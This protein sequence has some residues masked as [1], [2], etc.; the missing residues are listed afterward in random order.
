VHGVSA[1]V[2]GGVSGLPGHGPSGSAAYKGNAY[3]LGPRVRQEP[4]AAQDLPTP[5]GEGDAGISGTVYDVSG[6]RV[7]GAVVALSSLNAKVKKTAATDEEGSFRFEGLPEG[8]YQVEVSKPGF[9]LYQQRGVALDASKPALELSVVLAP[10]AVVQEVD[11]TAKGPAGAVPKPN[12]GSGQIWVDEQVEAEK[13]I[14]SAPP[15]Y[16][17]LAKMARIQ[18]TVRLAATISKDGTIQNLKV[19]AGHPLLVKAALESVQRW[20]YE[21]TLLNGQPVEVVTTIAVPFDQSVDVAAKGPSGAAWKPDLSP[22]RIRV[23]GLIEA[24]KLVSSAP[25]EYPQSARERG[26]QGV[27]VLEGVISMQGEPLSLKVLNSPDPDLA[28]AAL[29]AVKQWRYEPTLLNG[30]PIEVVSTIAVRF[31]LEP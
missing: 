26:I 9:A 10:G 2:L 27:V 14:S 6:A 5:D 30:E 31:H 20:R 21:P 7:P 28:K 3:A 24:T 1:G 17:P 8:R 12:V 16:P 11:V 22:K 29:D 15:E 4:E 25:P 23:G 18:G 19:I 13:L